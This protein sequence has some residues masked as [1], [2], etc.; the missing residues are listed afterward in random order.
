M[1]WSLR[2]SIE[3]SVYNRLYARWLNIAGCDPVV[4]FTFDDFPVTAFV[5]GGRLLE[6][7]GARGTFYLAPGLLGQKTDVGDIISEEDVEKC[8]RAGHELAH[9]TWSHLD[10]SIA[11]KSAINEDI[12]KAI[13]YSGN[14]LSQ[15]FSF[16]F[17]RSSMASKKVVSQHFKTCRGIESGINRG[18]IDLLELKSNA[19]YSKNNNIDLLRQRINDLKEN[20]GWL[21]FYTHDVTSA[22][23]P[24]GCTEEDFEKLIQSVIENNIEIA[25][26]EKVITKLM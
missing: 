17:G 7:Y 3:K 10:C 14:I 8:I 2:N 11:E 16:P 20:G 24:Y 22:Y 12:L 4:S 1:L 6:N 19:V 21:I 26:V 5:N 23:S 13:R 18:I 25:T 15:N 9:H